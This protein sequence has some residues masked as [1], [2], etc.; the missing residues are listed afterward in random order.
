MIEEVTGIGGRI[1]RGEM[2]LLDF[3]FDVMVPE[4]R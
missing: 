1:K 2:T 4:V 3:V